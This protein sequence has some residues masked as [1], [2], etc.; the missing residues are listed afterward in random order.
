MVSLRRM[1]KPL[2]IFD[3]DGTLCDTFSVDD[4]CFCATASKMLGVRL[5]RTSWEGAPHITDAGILAWLWERH[6][7]RAPSWAETHAFIAAFEV[8]LR[9]EYG[10]ASEQFRPIVGAIELLDQLDT[11]GWVYA[12]AT[13]GWRKTARMKL[14]A[15]GLWSDRLFASADDSQN[16]QEIFRLAAARAVSGLAQPPPHLTVLVGDGTWDAAVAASCGWAFVGVAQGLR[17]SRLQDVG[18]TGV[19]PNLMNGD[20]VERVLSSCKPFVWGT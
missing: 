2:V 19:I 18:V 7:G 8:S 12:I 10:R 11:H 6:V 3:V 17:A 9:I 14:R 20:E 13:G 16:R 4:R 1:V 15:A 5:D